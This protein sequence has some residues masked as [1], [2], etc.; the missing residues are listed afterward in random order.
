MLKKGP[1]VLSHEK[2]KL[3]PDAIVQVLL[4]SLL[5]DDTP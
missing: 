5:I 1:L 2:Q 3:F 4:S